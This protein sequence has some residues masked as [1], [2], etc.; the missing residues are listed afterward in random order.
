M[1]FLTIFQPNRTQS[2][3]LMKPCRHLFKLHQTSC[4]TMSL[5]RRHRH[6]DNFLSLPFWSNGV[7][8]SLISPT[9]GLKS[10]L[11]FIRTSQF[12][13]S[14]NASSKQSRGRE[15][16]RRKSTLVH[17][18]TFQ[19]EQHIIKAS[20]YSQLHISTLHRDV[21][22]STQIWLRPALGSQTALIY[23]DVSKRPITSSCIMPKIYMSCQRYLRRVVLIYT[24]HGQPPKI[25]HCGSDFIEWWLQFDPSS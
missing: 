8:Q 22:L 9:L 3:T 20:V 11:G 6:T 19:L 16:L 21:D 7:I 4:F 13:W 18:L 23:E 25:I 5:Q 24:V 10:G 1:S 15:C 2:E 17:F 12:R 14:S